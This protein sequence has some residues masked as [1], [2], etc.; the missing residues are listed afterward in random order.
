MTYAT[1]YLRW[2]ESDLLTA[3]Q[4]QE[5]LDLTDEGEIQD[6]FYRALSFGTS[7]LR[8]VMG[9]GL[10]RMNEYIIRQAADAFA[11]V[12]LERGQAE[13]GVCICFDC[14]HNSRKFA[15]E[16][17]HMM[18]ARGIPVYLFQNCRP[19]PQLSFAVRHFGAAAGI[20]VTASHN[21]KEYNGFKAYWQGGLPLN[22]EQAGWVAE[23][24]DRLDPLSPRPACDDPA[25]LTWLDEAFD[26]PYIEAVL[27]SAVAP[28][29]LRQEGFKVVYSAFHGVGGVIVPQVL[30][31]AGLRELIPV[32]EQFAPD[33]D[34]P[35]LIS[36]NPEDPRGFDR[37]I[38]LAKQENA[39][40]IIGTDPDSDRVAMVAKDRAGNYIPIS[41]NRTGALLIHYLLTVGKEKGKLPPH[42]ALVK[43][44]VTSPLPRVIAEAKGCLCRDTFT[45]FK[46]LAAEADRLNRETEYRYVL[47][48][49]ESIGYMVG[50]HARDKD[51]VVGAL[52]LCELAGWYR[53]RGMT[54]P[55]GLEALWQEYGCFSEVTRSVML[56]GQDGMERMAAIMAG[57]RKTPLT[58]IGG[59]AVRAWRDYGCGRRYAGDTVT[60]LELSGSNVVLYELES[61]ETLVVRPSGTEPKI[62]IYALMQGE[63]QADA[64]SRA[65]A[66]ALDAEARIHSRPWSCLPSYL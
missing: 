8:G 20:N 16:A 63:N 38:A 48:F 29:H 42:P 35:T 33:G 4:R 59:T 6:R 64:D 2:R 26:A 13:K 53:S 34:F 10:N 21:P 60:D 9:M 66:C 19:T 17:A 36:P 30:A 5:L 45:G 58:E 57:L 27:Q 32:P 47:A 15:E 43:T 3:A 22:D 31:Q 55:D 25:P 61:G 65:T 46:Y 54:V 49:E 7:G 23:Q 50:D 1:E 12:I 56:P 37:A 52:L 18:R 11:R 40:L 14:R 62:K 28:E 51:G 24:M 44:I 41:G 39:D